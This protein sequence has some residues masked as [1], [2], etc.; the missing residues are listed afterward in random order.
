M[1]SISHLLA[2]EWIIHGHFKRSVLISHQPGNPRLTNLYD[3]PH[4]TAGPSKST[5]ARALQ[6]ESIAFASENGCPRTCSSVDFEAG[7]SCVWNSRKEFPCIRLP[8]KSRL[9]VL[10]KHPT[11]TAYVNTIWEHLKS[12]RSFNAHEMLVI[13]VLRT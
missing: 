1:F 7:N 4:D 13:T 9:Q 10:V 3:R 12:S 11:F 6:L 2:W 5:W 8:A